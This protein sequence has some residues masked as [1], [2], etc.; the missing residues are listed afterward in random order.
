M[1]L[2][3][4]FF[5]SGADVYGAGLK[6]NEDGT[7]EVISDSLISDKVE[8]ISE[9]VDITERITAYNVLP[10]AETGS[11]QGYFY[12]QLNDLD[13]QIYDTIDSEI[14]LILDGTIDKIEFVIPDQYNIY[15]Y[16][17]E[18]ESEKNRYYYYDENGNEIDYNLT[19]AI[20]TYLGYDHMEYFW[21]N[22]KTISF[23]IGYNPVSKRIGSLIFLSGDSKYAPPYDA[24]SAPEEIEKVD[25]RTNDIITDISENATR[26]KKLQIIN[27]WLV[28]NNTYNPYVA[29]GGE[30]SDK[31]NKVAW[32]LTSA[33]LYGN[34]DDDTMYPV[35]EGY[36]EAFKLLC[37]SMDIPCIIVTSE[38]HEWNAVQ[39]DDGKWYYVD[40]TFND[41]IIVANSEA[42]RKEL[43]EE[44][45]YKHFLI[46]GNNQNIVND[47]DHIVS[48]YEGLELPV[49]ISGDDYIYSNTGDAD[50]DGY[51]TEADAAL[52]LRDISGISKMTDE[53]AVSGD[54]DGD[55]EITL[56]DVTKLLEKIG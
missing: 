30:E 21:L 17:A 14:D 27:D 44:Y 4:A 24:S 1:F 40:V 6:I 43:I 2:T 7:S 18:N 52:M 16:K 26:Y 15:L 36:A 41:P 46:G 50:M 11:N 55:G 19:K 34:G 37:D 20:F 39:M 3:F 54:I 10:F 31:A 9:P 42:E 5:A 53:Q 51:L 25:S 38:T 13:K 8:I 48:L 22:N 28:D 23:G 47:E 33:L 32:I 29:A 12:D 45:R 35:C 49:G 56:V